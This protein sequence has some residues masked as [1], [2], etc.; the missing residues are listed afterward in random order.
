MRIAVGTLRHETNGF[1]PLFTDEQKFVYSTEEKVIIENCL[2][3]NVFIEEQ[4]EMVPLI[5]A[6]GMPGGMVKE[7]TFLKHVEEI[8]EKLKKAGNLDGIFLNLH[9]AMEVENIG[10]GELYLMK[11]IRKITGDILPIGVVMDTHGNNTAEY[12]AMVDV[13]RAYRSVPHVDMVESGEVVAR[14]LIRGI[15]HNIKTNPCFI[16]LPFAIQG[17]KAIDSQYPLNE[18]FTRL[19]QI[20]EIPGI[21]IATMFISC[22]WSDCYNRCAS[23]A[24]TPIS[25]EYDELAQQK[26]IE[27]AEFVTSLKDQFQFAAE[28]MST[29]A[30]IRYAQNKNSNLPFFITDSGDNVTGGG[31]GDSTEILREF[32]SKPDLAGKKICITGIWDRDTV[33]K[34]RDIEI[35]QTLTLSVGSGREDYAKKVELAG[36]IQ[37]K[38]KM[39][40]FFD[41]S[42]IGE[43][44]T[45]SCGNIHCTFT[46]TPSS[47]T[48][49]EHFTAAGLQY[50]DYDV[51]VVKQ[52]YLFASLSKISSGYIMALTNGATNQDISKL[53]YKNI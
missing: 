15:T 8:C 2:G 37:A 45:L 20:E 38:G 53:V 41:K 12:M 17:E 52:G 19:Y 6:A 27:L 26:C 3:K 47:F 21:S 42:P 48:W 14:H 16:S 34:C 31:V 5:Y 43:T 9:G 39:L 24:V 25:P 50:M 13:V 1:N 33:E 18:I 7:T 30:A 36:T 32:L 10:S 49:P 4:V 46:D 40:A 35:G 23:V 22:I 51:I 44:V 29:E 11:E 28:V